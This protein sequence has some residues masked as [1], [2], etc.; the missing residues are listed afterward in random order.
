MK[1]ILVF[2][3]AVLLLSSIALAEE[4]QGA[5][6]SGS[7]PMSVRYNESS[8]NESVIP[9][10]NKT[11][12]PAGRGNTPPSGLRGNESV[13]KKNATG[14]LSEINGTLVHEGIFNALSHVTNEN[15]RAMLQR[16]MERFIE[17]YQARLQNMSDVNITVDE[18]HGNATIKAKENV[19][20][21]GF[22][23][24]KATKRFEID[25]N[26]QVTERQPWYSFMYKEE[27]Q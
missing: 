2:L 18:E 19:R 26:G 27:T 1:K 14:P 17:R 5:G 25:N 6:V 20:F 22:I 4:M 7:G 3:L 9:K 10:D 24:G 12:P 23:K 15:A 8:G 16:N 11:L 21:L 13:D